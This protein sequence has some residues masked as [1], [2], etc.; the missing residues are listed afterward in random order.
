MEN[1]TN[2]E[3]YKYYYEYW[4]NSKWDT[5]SLYNLSTSDLDIS[6]IRQGAL[7]YAIN[8][9]KK[10]KD[11]FYDKLTKEKKHTNNIF[12]IKKPLYKLYEMLSDTNDKEEII[13]IIK[14]SKEKI[15]D[16]EENYISYIKFHRK[17]EEEQLMKSLTQ[18]I[19]FYKEYLNNNT[20]IN[21]NNKQEDII[22]NANELISIFAIN[23][24]ISKEEFCIS[25]NITSDEFQELINIVKD[26][27]SPIYSIF[28]EKIEKQKQKDKENLINA[29][30][31]II[32]K[33]NEKNFSILDYYLITNTPMIDF[34][35]IA[36]KLLEEEKITYK[37]FKTLERF[38]CSNK[39][40]KLCKQKD[41]DKLLK[42][43]L[44]INP[45]LND[46]DTYEENSGHEITLE[47]KEEVLE[48]LK[49]KNIPVTTLT[50]CLA[51]HKYC[52]NQEVTRK[53]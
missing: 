21:E 33:L 51:I 4:E 43:K 19:D 11:D 20:I 2:K 22:A 15:S 45:K 7:N 39:N 18:K 49:L 42:E 8:N 27:N 37:D 9:L 10:S 17:Y 5:N 53:R 35:D 23:P 16:I 28:I 13:K 32:T 48:D 24:N 36:K 40:L 47:E 31:F 41:I 30:P 26:N 46:D 6:T 38:I 50:F 3:I 44:I 29:I 14:N 25:H 12:R 1:K 34:L 52:N